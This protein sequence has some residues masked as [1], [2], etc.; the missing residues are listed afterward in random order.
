MKNNG[1]RE[2][3]KAKKKEQE[4]K[5]ERENENRKQIVSIDWRMHE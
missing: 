5:Q 3:R 4:E 1:G 2:T